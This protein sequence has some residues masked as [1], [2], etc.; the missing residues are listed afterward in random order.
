MSVQIYKE[1]FLNKIRRRKKVYTKTNQEY[2]DN[3]K[4]F[5]D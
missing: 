5:L 4:E 2:I 3:N 1:I